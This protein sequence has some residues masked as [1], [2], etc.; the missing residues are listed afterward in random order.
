MD[1]EFTIPIPAFELKRQANQHKK[2]LSKEHREK[3]KSILS[4]EEKPL[5]R[6]TPHEQGLEAVAKVLYKIAM[7]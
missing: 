6:L 4:I 1:K 3:L 7:P 2:P 5:Q